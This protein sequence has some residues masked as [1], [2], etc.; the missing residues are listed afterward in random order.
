MRKQPNVLYASFEAVPF[1]KTGGLGDVGGTLPQALEKAGCQTRVI[2]PKLLSI[3]QEYRAR[4][5]RV[6]EFRVRL[7]WRDLYCG[8]EMLQ[9]GGM[10]YYFLDNEYYFKRESPY[11]YFDDGE[12]IAFFAMAVAESIGHLPDFRCDILHCND[13]HTAL[14]PIFLRELYQGLPDYAAVKTVFTV[15]NIKFQGEYSD[16]MLGDV[17]GLS[18]IAAAENQ[19][20]SGAGSINF[21]KGA[22]SYSDVL[23]T[24]SPSYAEELRYP[25]YGEG[26]DEIFRRRESVLFGIL[27]GIDQEEYNPARDKRIEQNFSAA[28]LSGKA[29]CK[30]ALQ[31][32]LG[33]AQS[34]EPP[35]VVMIGRLTEQKG[36]DLVERVLDEILSAGL[37]MAVLGTGD[38]N[39]EEMLRDVERRHPGALSVR[40]G[41]DAALSNRMYAG[42]DLLLMPSLFEPC[43]LSQMIAMRY[44]TLPVVRAT[45]GLRDSVIPYNEETG[46]GNGFRFWNYNA[47]EMKDALLAA[48]ALFREDKARWKKLMQQAMAADFSW[49]RAAGTYLDIYRGLLPGGEGERA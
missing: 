21:M 2:L 27:N 12:R 11:G 4:M 24:V 22:L 48:A 17:L 42:A 18:G 49:D 14:C 8:V 6:A 38:Q 34:P 23:T 32:E 13:W 31:R 46:E 45:G 30:A 40:L 26:L 20:R 29:L 5:E 44:G 47:H 36:L 39:Y 10:S 19:L 43:G 25:F 35:L 37:Q 16:A 33:L 7:G 41:F 9:H 15:H 3:P 1:I 28:D